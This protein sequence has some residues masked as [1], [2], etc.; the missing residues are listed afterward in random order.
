MC[1]YG[2]EGIMKPVPISYWDSASQT[3]QT[4]IKQQP[5]SIHTKAFSISFDWYPT[6]QYGSITELKDYRLRTTVVY[7]LDLFI[8]QIEDAV[9]NKF[10][11]MDE[12]VKQMKNECLKQGVIVDP[13]LIQLMGMPESA[14][15]VKNGD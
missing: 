15:A 5:D 1:F 11:I 9:V 3:I 10:Q 2:K 8:K 13:D 6:N 7:D 12:L 4:V 14:M